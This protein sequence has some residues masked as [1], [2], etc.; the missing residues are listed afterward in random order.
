MQRPMEVEN[1][2]KR[3]KVGFNLNSGALKISTIHSF[4]VYEVPTLI[5]II[6]DN[7]NEEIVYTGI[8]RS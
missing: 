7:D 4:K 2:R 5:L 3:K 6:V 1:V 8:T